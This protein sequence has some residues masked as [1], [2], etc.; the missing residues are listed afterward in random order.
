MDAHLGMVENPLI[1]RIICKGCPVFDRQFSLDLHARLS[2]VTVT[3]IYPRTK[4]KQLTGR[5][6]QHRECLP[7]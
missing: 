4:G 5:P 7:R 3:L 6:Q 2:F 1:V